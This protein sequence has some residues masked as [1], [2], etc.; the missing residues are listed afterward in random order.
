MRNAYKFPIENLEERD[1]LE[2]KITDWTMILKLIFKNGEKDVRLIHL[3]Q[4]R[5]H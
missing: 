3:P 1:I 5:V 2:D 4:N